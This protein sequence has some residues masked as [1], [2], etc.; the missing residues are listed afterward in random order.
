MARVTDADIELFVDRLEV[1]YN[2][3]FRGKKRGRFALSREQVKAALRV[4]A[5]HQTT[6]Y[7]IQ[8]EAQERGYIFINNDS[9]FPVVKTSITNTYRKVT[10]SSFEK[11]FKISKNSDDSD[12]VDESDESE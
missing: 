7:R 11:V 4:K 10:Q 2:T 8:D 9:L 12:G 6:I 1:L 5:L 3:N